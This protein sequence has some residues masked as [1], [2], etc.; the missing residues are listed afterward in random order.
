MATVVPHVVGLL[1]AILDTSDT[2]T[3]GRLTRVVLTELTGVRQDRLEELDGDDLDAV[4]E[5]GVDTRDTD[6]L[7]DTQVGQVLLPEGHPEACTADRGIVLHER[8]QLLVVE[9]V[10]LTHPDIGIGQ[11]LVDLLRLGLAPLPILV[12]LT[13]L[14]DLADVDLG[15]EVR[16]E[17]LV[18][19]P[20]VAVYD[21][22]VVD[23]IEVVLGS[24]GGEDPGHPWVEATAQDSRQ[25]SFFEALL[26]GPLPAVLEL[27]LVERLIV[28][29]VEVVDACLEASIH[30]M[31]V[32]IGQSDIDDQLWLEGLHQSDELGDV[33]S[34]DGCRLDLDIG[35]LG[36]NLIALTL[37]AAGEHNLSEYV[38]ILCHLL[39]HYRTDTAGTD[40]EDSSHTL[41]L[42]F[43]G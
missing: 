12:V 1:L 42:V 22:E 38:A 37:R 15:I 32:L 9:E 27:S 2:A 41:F 34:V 35:N 20:T 31:E 23:L 21:I 26:V 18:V 7:H 11:G 16:G 14:S 36:G 5:D 30:D 8:L 3:D 29:R 24:I 28:R 40:N 10:R 19:V 25:P 13:L 17:G 33:I 6:I 4:V 39:G 43:L